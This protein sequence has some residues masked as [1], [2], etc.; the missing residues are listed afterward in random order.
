MDLEAI[1]SKVLNVLE[2][3][4][5]T[6]IGFGIHFTYSAAA[7]YDTVAISNREAVLN[8]Q[9]FFRGRSKGVQWSMEIS[10]G[11][12]DSEGHLQPGYLRLLEGPVA[13]GLTSE[14]KR[15]LE[16]TLHDLHH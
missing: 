13:T 8:R 7:F 1:A 14:E 9:L 5:L 3:H 16:D 2:E 4:D 10:R 12:I 11:W 6:P 15:L